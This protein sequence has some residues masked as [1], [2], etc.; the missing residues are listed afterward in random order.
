MFV[1]ELPTM[2]L[3]IVDAVK[4]HLKHHASQRG[5]LCGRFP[6]TIFRLF[7]DL[8]KLTEEQRNSVCKT[9][10]KM[11]ESDLQRKLD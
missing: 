10:L 3:R 6:V 11:A 2:I 8:P 5:S 4:I 1:R 9:C 7:K